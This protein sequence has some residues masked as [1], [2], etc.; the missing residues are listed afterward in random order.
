MQ[1]ILIA[2]KT[3][4]NINKLHDLWVIDSG[5]T[6]HMTNQFSKLHDFKKLP[7]PSYVSVANGEGAKVLGIGKIN[8][9]SDKIESKALYVPSFPFQ[10]LSVGKMTH[11]LNCLVTFSPYNVI[12]QDCVTKKKIGESVFLDGLYYLSKESSFL[13]GFQVNSNL[14]QDQR[15][16]H[17]RLAH[18]SKL[19]LSSLFPSFC[20]EVTQCD[21]CHLSKSAR[22][23]L[24]P[25]AN[26]CIFLDHSSTQK[27]YM[28]YSPELKK[29]VVSN[30]VRFDEASSYYK[31]LYDDQLQGESSLE[32]FPLPKAEEHF[33]ETLQTGD[34]SSADD[35]PLSGHH[36]DHQTH[37]EEPH[38]E[39][40]EAS[41]E[42]TSHVQGKCNP[43]RARHPPT[44]LQDYVTY[45]ARHQINGYMSYQ[46]VSPF[47]TAYLNTISSQCE[48]QSF[49]EASCQEVWNNVM[50]EELQALTNHKTWSVV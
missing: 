5:T 16:W 12:F 40:P 22:D 14:A 21:T 26:K 4:L 13:K 2:L 30:D 17:Q 7:T 32:F 15:L 24:D 38:N 9:V 1:G 50:D 36:T 18:P 25:R 8:L 41:T 31:K 37:N 28:C 44:R 48:P 11:T 43:M 42:E 10:L 49:Q 34:C 39:E 35:V 46:N 27:G 33:S 3:A 19:I 47:Y 29:V 20:K 45:S 23:K 6:Y